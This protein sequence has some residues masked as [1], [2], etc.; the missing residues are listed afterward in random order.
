MQNAK[1]TREWIK[2]TADRIDEAL[3]D[4]SINGWEMG[5]LSDIKRTLSAGKGITDKQERRLVEVLIKAGAW[6]CRRI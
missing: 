2:L 1:R 3:M 6:R 5:F 4:S